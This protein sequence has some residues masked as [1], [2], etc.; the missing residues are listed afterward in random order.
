[1]RFSPW[2]R[3]VVR[4]KE[5]SGKCGGAGVSG[6]CLK[7]WGESVQKTVSFGLFLPLG[8]GGSTLAVGRLGRGWLQER[9]G[10]SKAGFCS[11]KS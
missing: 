11:P 9:C 4:R 10:L 2:S 3:W 8:V 1:M 7:N 6:A 5:R